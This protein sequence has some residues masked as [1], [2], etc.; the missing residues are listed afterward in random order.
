MKRVIASPGIYIQEPGALASLAQD[1]A[2][3]GDRG[4]YLL[5]AGF[6]YDHCLD[7]IAAG[8]KERGMR[9][10]AR[11]FGGECSD[12]EIGRHLAQLDGCDVVVSIGGGKALDA[13]KAIAWRAGLPDVIVPTAASSDAPCSRLAVIYAQDHRFERYQPLDANPSAVV[14]DTDVIAH[15]PARLLAAGIGDAFSTYYEAEACRRSHAETLMGGHASRAA[16]GLARLCR[17]MLLAHGAEALAA[18]GAHQVTPALEDVV[19]ANI[20]LSGVGFESCGEAAAHAIANGLGALDGTSGLMHGEKVAFGTVCQMILE[21]RPETELAEAMAFLRACGL[22]ISMAGLGIAGLPDED[23][24]EACR[25]ACAP[26]ETMGNM[27]FPVS[28]E[29]VLAAM[30]ETDALAARLAG[31]GA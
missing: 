25:L 8:F 20:Y 1:C 6:A 29:D 16:L 18:A 27:D 2:R 7:A 22:P 24:L 4:A 30:R 13:A 31:E 19:E 11:R 28:A 5:M 17:E 15:A 3:L 12:A 9:L 10:V 23:V 14:V 21:G 26:G